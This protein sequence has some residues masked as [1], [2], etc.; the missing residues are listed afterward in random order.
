MKTI[1]NTLIALLVL[2]MNSESIARIKS[3]DHPINSKPNI[4]VSSRD[5]SNNGFDAP[6]YLALIKART[7]L[8]PLAEFVWGNP[9]EEAP[10]ELRSNLRIVPVQALIWSECI[11]EVPTDLGTI[12]ARLAMV[13]VPA[14]NWEDAD[15]SAAE[16]PLLR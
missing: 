12:K 5:W 15:I 11:A 13:P 9:E 10:I 7:A 8:V 4:P 6:K 14:K 3:D 1:F 16:T 2:F